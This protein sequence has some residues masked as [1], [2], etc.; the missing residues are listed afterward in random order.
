M[1]ILRVLATA[2]LLAAVWPATPAAAR[3]VPGT[4]CSV[5][6]SDNVWH[7]DVSKLPVAAKSRTWLHAMHAGT[8]FLHP[9]FG[10]PSYGI[11]Y[12]VV[13]AG[14]KKVRIRFRYASE[15][16]P[17]PYPFGK[18]IAIEGGS[19]RHSIMV[20]KSDCTLY[21]LYDARWNHG[22]P[23]AGSG[24][25][26][27]LTGPK[28]N[29]LRPDGWT[30][31][32]AAGLPIFA[33]L[34]RHDEVKAGVVDHAIRMTAACSSGHHVWP[35]RHDAATGGRKCPPM[36]ARF[37]LKAGFDLSGFSPKAKVVLRA[38]QTYGLIVADNGSDWYFQGTVD[39]RW[40]NR[41]L[42][43]LK[44]IPARAFVAV[45]ERGCKVGANTGRYANGPTCPAP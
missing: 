26:F 43:Q 3:S 12:D 9:D 44:R 25:V 38:M 17:G 11:P 32:D 34:L 2:A 42:D 30:S 21:E 40:T 41:L 27:H 18:D 36:G 28:A 20:D 22:D 35:A 23:T 45:D 14:H 16:D 37:R 15:S 1:T 5:F 19:D 13:G 10:P 24:A 33:G 39:K 31:A 7:L 4:S 29:R 8:T 6:P